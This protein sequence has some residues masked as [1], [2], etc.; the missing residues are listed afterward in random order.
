MDTMTPIRPM[1][2]QQQQLRHVSLTTG[3]SAPAQA[4]TE[5]RAAICAWGLPVDESVAALLISEL[6]SNAIRHETGPTI[7]LDVSRACGRLRVD[8]HDTSDA[9]PTPM[10]V[11]TDGEAGR[12]LLLVASLS[13]EWGFYRTPVGK[14]V[15]FTLDFPADPS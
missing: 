12:G 10:E 3:L 6:V 5:V 15:Y 4:R 1:S 7:V 11:P 13:D 8:V 14:A 2:Q 9:L